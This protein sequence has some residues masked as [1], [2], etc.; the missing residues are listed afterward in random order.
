MQLEDLIDPVYITQLRSG[1][2]SITETQLKNPIVKLQPRYLPLRQFVDEAFKSLDPN[3]MVETL[4]LYKKPVSTGNW[5]HEQRSGLFNQLLA[6][7]TMT[8]IQYYSASRKTMRTFFESSIVIDGPD[9]KRP[10]PDPVYNI[11]PQ[12]LTLYT[13][14]KDLTFGE[15]IYR[16]DYRTTDSAFFFMQENL[17]VMNA[18]IIPAIGKNKLRS[19]MAVINCDDSLLIYAVSMARV[20]SVLGM[21]DR[22]SSSFSNRAEAILKW[23]TTGADKL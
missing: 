6:L 10:V 2:S 22:I 8:G 16:Y 13:R 4:Y 18:G 20:T 5:N 17:T 21:G 1:N 15:N 14:Q 19:V 9:S 23:F 7:S 3:V 12:S 11:P